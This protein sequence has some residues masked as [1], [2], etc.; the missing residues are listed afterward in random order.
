MAEVEAAVDLRSAVVGGLGTDDREL[1]A[2]LDVLVA[3]EALA[4]VAR[5]TPARIH[6][7]GVEAVAFTVVDVDVAIGAVGD[8]I[9]DAGHHIVHIL[10][11]FLGQEFGN[12]DFGHGDDVLELGAGHLG[13][14]LVLTAITDERHDVAHLQA[15]LLE[16]ALRTDAIDI[17]LTRP[18]ADVD[19]AIAGVR[20]VGDDTG[21]AILRAADLGC[22]EISHGALDDGTLLGHGQFGLI[23]LAAA[24][25]LEHDLGVAVAAGV[26]RGLELH[27]VAA[28]RRDGEPIGRSVDIDA[29]TLVG[30]L[31]GEDTALDRENAVFRI[32]FLNLDE[33]LVDIDDLH[34]HEFD[35]AV[36]GGLRTGD[37]HFVTYFDAEARP[38]VAAGGI[39]GTVDVDLTGSV[40]QIPVAIVGVGDADAGTGHLVGLAVGA[41]DDLGASGGRYDRQALDDIDDLGLATAVDLDLS[42]TAVERAAC[43]ER[44]VGRTCAAR[45]RAD[46]Q[47]VGSRRDGPA[48]RSVD[49]NVAGTT[50]HVERHVGRRHRHGTQIVVRFNLVATG[51]ESRNGNEGNKDILDFHIA[52]LLIS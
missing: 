22:E 9:E 16:V 21:D 8:L 5:S 24:L 29:R 20:H 49:R 3:E 13:R 23:G 51:C 44:D 17:G 34:V 7:V 12:A 28:D 27:G 15:E 48:F 33:A 38:G 32:H 35:R 4:G 43:G 1:V 40:L 10:A 31:H 50:A 6:T 47:P 45:S 37:G 39:D 18:V 41:G 36:V 30:E 14:A 42:R 25:G 26:G 52:V 11:V 46:G 2:D 19:V